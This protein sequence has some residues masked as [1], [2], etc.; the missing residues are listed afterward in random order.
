MIH[1]PIQIRQDYSMVPA[2]IEAMES[3]KNYK[4]NQ[5]VQAKVS[6]IQKERSVRQLGLFFACCNTVAENTEDP[7]WDNK[8][9]VLNQVKVALQFIDLNKSIVDE[10]GVFHPHYR[11]ISFK[12]LRHL[13]ACNFF[14]RA[15]PILA[16]KLG[17]K[18]DELLNNAGVAA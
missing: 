17:V 9:K 5:I 10:K 14:D 2:T 6:G 8:D 13:D 11:S 1:I 4:P 16:C 15:W 3:L 12:N 18:V 7:N